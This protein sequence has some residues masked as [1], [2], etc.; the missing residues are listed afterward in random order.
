MTVWN[1]SPRLPMRYN[2][3]AGLLLAALPFAAFGIY[4]VST[5]DTVDK[6][7]NEVERKQKDLVKLVQLQIT[8][9]ALADS[10]KA[11]IIMSDQKWQTLYDDASIDF[12]KKWLS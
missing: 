7:F 8:H 3:L 4:S 2:L 11:F 10:V 6:S 12:D 9:T 1:F 5:L